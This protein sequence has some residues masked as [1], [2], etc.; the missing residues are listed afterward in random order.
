[1]GLFIA[2]PAAPAPTPPPSPEDDPAR[3]EVTPEETE[4]SIGVPFSPLEPVTFE[5]AI[6][7]VFEGLAME[8]IPEAV[9]V[10]AV[11]EA[12]MS[13]LRVG[14]EGAMS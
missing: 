11:V 14:L 5:L 1:M 6:R 8:L 2:P 12:R 13:E 7:R 9:V 3:A 4:C 10:V